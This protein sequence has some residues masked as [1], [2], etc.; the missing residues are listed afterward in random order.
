MGLSKGRKLRA[1]PSGLLSPSTELLVEGLL[2]RWRKEDSKHFER[3]GS[4]NR[5]YVME[6]VGEQK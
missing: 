4:S 5:Y 2:S 6:T 1:K 3:K